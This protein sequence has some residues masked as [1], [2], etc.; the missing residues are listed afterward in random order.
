MKTL[1]ISQP[2][3]GKFSGTDSGADF[4]RLGDILTNIAGLTHDGRTL[5]SV[6]AP[7]RHASSNPVGAY[8][9]ASTLICVALRKVVQA[10]DSHSLEA[11][12]WFQSEVISGRASFCPICAMPVLGDLCR[13]C[14]VLDDARAQERDAEWIETANEGTDTS[15]GRTRDL[16]DA[17]LDLIREYFHTVNAIATAADAVVM[18]EIA[19]QAAS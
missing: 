9:L 3:A 17:Q 16:A 5:R 1:R 19:A 8:R 11:L 10:T 15:E 18:S 2:T 7:F 6:M 4:T 13:V 14:L 12:H